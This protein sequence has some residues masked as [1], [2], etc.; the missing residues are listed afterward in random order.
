MV[1]TFP[2]FPLTSPLKIQNRKQLSPKL[3]RFYYKKKIEFSSIKKL[4]YDIADTPTTEH[5]PRTHTNNSTTPRRSKPKHQH[6]S[7]PTTRVTALRTR[8]LWKSISHSQTLQL[9]DCFTQ[10][11]RLFL[12][13]FMS[14]YILVTS[15]HILSILENQKIFS[16]TNFLIKKMENKLTWR[17]DFVWGFLSLFCTHN[18]NSSK[19]YLHA[20]FLAQTFQ[21]WCATI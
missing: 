12:T 2:K 1:W 3:H 17:L 4:I 14:C 20:H 21:L 5:N 7:I 10:Y 15:S 9:Q 13:I 16:M 11:Q 19:L 6:T 8:T 18:Y